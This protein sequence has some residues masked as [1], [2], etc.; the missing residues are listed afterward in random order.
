MMKSPFFLVE[1]SPWPLVTSMLTFSMMMSMIMFFHFNNMLMMMLMIMMLFIVAFQWWRDMSRESSFQGN[2]PFQLKKGLKIGMMLFIISELFF[3]LSFFWAFFHSS[4]SPNVEIGS[5]WPPKNI[6]P[7]MPF[8]IPLL[9]TIILL[10]SGVTV[11]WAHHSML[12]KNKSQMILSLLMT[13]MLGILFTLLQINEYN[14]AQYSISDSIYGSTFFVT[15]GFHG[16]HVII[17]TMFLSIMYFRMK[18]NLMSSNHH[19]SFE[20]SIWYWH[21]VDIIWIFLFTFM[22]WWIY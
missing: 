4:L 5:I 6:I 19:F 1:M 22:Y 2:H 12:S 16:L 20:A 18:N 21:F 15:T 7:L 13:I 11:T 8:T 14:Q 17:G 9:N 10:S 3:F